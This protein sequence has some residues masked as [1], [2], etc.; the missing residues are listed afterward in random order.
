MLE[1][2]KK[3][4]E[5]YAEI[6]NYLIVGGLTTVIS[7]GTKYALLFT[8]LDAKNPLQLQISVVVSWIA[9]VLFAYVTN[10]KYVFKSKDKNVLHELSLF[11]S[12]RIATLVMESVFMWFFVTF[13]KLN[14]DFY[15]I[16]WT[17]VSQFLVLIGNYVLSKFLVFKNKKTI[18]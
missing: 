10:R 5:K 14:S 4:Y 8:V 7:L 6:I 12:A 15:V 17:I 2:I 3:L 13:L 1:K 11:I 9:A 18:K 16:I